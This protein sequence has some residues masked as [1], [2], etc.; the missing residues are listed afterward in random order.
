[1]LGNSSVV[2]PLLVSQGYGSIYLAR[3]YP[4]RLFPSAFTTKRLYAFICYV[5]ATRHAHFIVWR[6]LSREWEP[7][8]WA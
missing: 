5:R 7:V 8:L 6:H 4:K 2:K 3:M 1:M